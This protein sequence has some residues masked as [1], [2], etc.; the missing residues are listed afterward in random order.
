MQ[1][2]RVSMMQLMR[3]LLQFTTRKKE[4]SKQNPGKKNTSRTMTWKRGGLVVAAV[5]QATQFFSRRFRFSIFSFRSFLFSKKQWFVL[6]VLL[7]SVA[8]LFSDSI[9]SANRVVIGLILAVLT[10]LLLYLV[11]KKDLKFDPS[12]FA[13]FILP[14][15]YTF[16]FNLFYL[17]IPFRLITRVIT[18]GVFAFGLYSLF[19][20]QNIFAVSSLRTITLM[21]SARIILFVITIAVCFLS[22]NIMF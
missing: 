9:I 8:M 1:K 17:L 3:L 14:F 21:R 18:T 16:S 22:M 15:L 2:I 11:L 7:L 6:I 12:S 5:M 10:D 20:T 4:R 19:L 13:V